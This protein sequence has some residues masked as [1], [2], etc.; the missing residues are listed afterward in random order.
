MTKRTLGQRIMTANLKEETQV[1]EYFAVRFIPFEDLFRNSR[2]N[3]Y[4]LRQTIDAVSF[5]VEDNV[6]R[7]EDLSLNPCT[8]EVSRGDRPVSLRSLIY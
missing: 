1:P 7:F 6:L 3:E 2:E 5:E 8:R 4:A